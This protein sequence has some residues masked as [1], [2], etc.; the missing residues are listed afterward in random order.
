M[1]KYDYAPTKEIAISDYIDQLRLSSEHIHPEDAISGILASGGI[2]VLAHPCYG[3]GVELILGEALN[4]RVRRL[5][6]YGLQGLEAF[7]SGFPESSRSQVLALSERYGLYITAGS[8]YHGT[9]KQ[10]ALGNTG[11]C[12]SQSLPDGLKRF[13]HR[14]NS[15]TGQMHFLIDY[16]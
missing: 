16:C 5:M 12:S 6:K 8:D 14:V 2:P 10:V 1:V 4:E 9:N 3:S 7:Y 13:L 15:I 11:L